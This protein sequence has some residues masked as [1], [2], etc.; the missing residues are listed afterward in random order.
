MNPDRGDLPQK[1]CDSSG[2]KPP[3]GQA[4][5]Y[6]GTQGIYG[7]IPPLVKE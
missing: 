7:S 6:P 5:G 3:K 1:A 2:E 4:G